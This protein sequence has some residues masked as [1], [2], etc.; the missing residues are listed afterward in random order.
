MVSY[1]GFTNIV[2]YVWSHSLDNASDSEDFVPNASQP[3]NSTRPDLE[4][5]DSNFDIRNR[6]TWIFGYELPA[7]SG[8]W[9]KLKNGWGLDSTVSYQTGQPF[10]LNY[11]FEDDFSGSGEGF[12]RPDVVGQVKYSNNPFQFLD[13]SAFA[14]P[15]TTTAYANLNGASGTAQDCV[16]GTRHFGGLPRNSLRAL[17]YKNWDLALSKKTKIT[18]TTMLEMRAEFFN[19]PNHPNFA[20]PL[21]PNF[22][23]DA[24]YNGFNNPVNGHETS[25]GFYPL[26]ATGDVGIGN[27]FLG[28]GAPRGIQLAAVFRF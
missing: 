2:N 16:P 24:A 4:Y 13:L 19:L 22:I 23:A 9:A 10:N 12:D 1:K 5:G 11:N 25:N 6:V 28:G 26:Q 7:Q 21:L 17:S 18:E 27:P 20:N 8:S 3:N 14:I 15:C